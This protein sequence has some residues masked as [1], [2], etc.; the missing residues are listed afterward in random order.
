MSQENSVSL[1]FADASGSLA[2]REA[3]VIA[4][5]RM[6]ALRE[7]A[8]ELR[9]QDASLREAALRVHDENTQATAGR[10]ALSKGQLREA[11]ERLVIASLRAQTMTEEA[12]RVTAHIS[13]M[14]QHD[15]LTGLPNRFLLTDRLAQAL[16]FA[17]RHRKRVALMY[18]DLDL[19]KHTNDS[20]GHAVGD[21][22]IQAVARRLQDNVRHSDTISRQGGDEFVVLL[23]EVE[24]VHNADLNA[25]KLLLAMA[26][27]FYIDGHVLHITASI[28]V[29]V[30]PDNSTDVDTLVRN[31]DIAMY[32]AKQS[33]RNNYQLF[34]E[35]MNMRVVARQSVETALRKALDKHEF[36]LHYQPKVSFESGAIT[37]AEALLRVQPPDEALIYPGQFVRVAEDCGLIVPIGRWAL[38]EACQQA[39]QWLKDGFDVGLIAVNVSAIEFRDK[40]FMTEVRAILRETGLD[41]HKLELELTESGLMQ[42]TSRTMAVLHALR[43]LGVQIA[44]D[45]FGTGYSSLSYLQRFPIDTLKIDQSFVQDIQNDSEEALLVNAIIAMGK[46]LK[47][48]VVA[49]GVET[50]QQ[51]AYLRSQFCTEGQGYYFGRPMDA[52][53]FGAVLATRRR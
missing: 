7:R 25:A 39:A 22:L 45:D 48:R 11:N 35:D 32:Q 3:A 38:R 44:I 47:L 24:S 33:G 19:F 2:E 28:G 51:L 37:G 23:A 27:P 50:H 43:E 18:L 17:D 53:H 29:S 46:S 12:E 15:G 52:A 8:A 31:A 10:E 34:S 5:E 41:P 16:V 36:V 20:L 6:T 21:Q 14:A 4:S 30:Y 26:E 40:G 9:E 1:A 13:H 49:E 42:D